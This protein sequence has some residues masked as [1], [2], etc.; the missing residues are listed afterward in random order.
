[1]IEI[2]R[3]QSIDGKLYI[4]IGNTRI[5]AAI[6]TKG[7]W[8]IVFSGQLE[9]KELLREI[10]KTVPQ[11]INEVRIAS[12]K[13]DAIEKITTL[14]PDRSLKKVMVSHIDPHYLDYH[15]VSTLGIDRFLACLGA[16][17]KCEAAVV[18]V[19]AGTACTIDFMDRDR[20][21][22]GGYITPGLSIREKGLHEFAPALPLVP[23]ELPEIW[24][25]RSTRESLQWGITGGFVNEIRAAIQN[26]K[27]QFSDLQ[28]WLT[29]GDAE[30]IEKYMTMPC[31][32]SAHLVF[33][34]MRV[35]PCV[36]AS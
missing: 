29:G 5:K 25:G 21:F 28:V 10:C 1:M 23:R 30:I 7:D 13:N 2:E 31:H 26:Y 4:D 19:D 15:T 3:Y 36:E 27:R 22:H 12:V 9:D 8:E 32:S 35:F 24:P 16:W 11:D 20:V 33:E 6:F 14:L 34:G 18:V 17:H